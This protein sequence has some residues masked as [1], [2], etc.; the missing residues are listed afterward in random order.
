MMT[1]STGHRK[2]Q[3]SSCR[4]IRDRRSHGASLLGDHC[5]GEEGHRGSAINP[6]TSGLKCSDERCASGE[7]RTRVVHCRAGVATE[8]RQP[9]LG[10][11]LMVLAM[12]VVPFADS[13]GK[14]LSGSH[15]PILVSW[16]RYVAG[17]AFVLPVAL[18]GRRGSWI[19]RGRMPA[20][21]V[22]A[23]C[24]I[25]GMVLYQMSIALVPLTDALGAS[26][27]APIVALALATLMLGEPLRGRRVGAVL[28]GFL[29]ALLVVRPG[30]RLDLGILF[31]LGSGVSMGCYLIA[32]RRV[33]Q[34]D[35]PLGTLAFQYALGSLL[36]TPLGLS[37]W[38][39]LAPPELPLILLMGLLSV[40]FNFLVIAAF[41][42]TQA[43]ALLPLVYVELLGTTMLGFVVFHDF[44]S[45]VTWSGIGLIVVGGLMLIER[46]QTLRCR[47]ASHGLEAERH[48]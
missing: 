44:P 22:R 3:S 42:R 21:A 12:L 16:A 10:V 1:T 24:L 33:A 43:S 25:A 5:R 19:H 11:A 18:L 17:S 7:A 34:A 13:I 8:S 23:M 41:R 2:W 46:R 30:P 15:S 36:L 40:A 29:G 20:Q 6:S 27:I 28:L 26:L 47:D 39:P 14:Y 37:R 9:L 48:G 31:A 45:L 32:T 35:S 38:T 4:H